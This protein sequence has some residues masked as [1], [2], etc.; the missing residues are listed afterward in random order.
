MRVVGT[1]SQATPSPRLPTPLA[2]TT[3][4]GHPV[5]DAPNPPHQN[6]VGARWRST[7]TKAGLEGQ[8]LHDVRHF[9]ASGLVSRG[10]D[11]VTVQP[12]LGHAR[13]TTT[14]DT[15]S[16]LWPTAE[17]RTRKAAESMMIEAL[18]S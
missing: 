11:V 3:Q 13:A 15:W 9:F 5:L 7:L 14:L 12:A 10:C 8:K 16:H 1:T 4:V 6:T 2:Q 17:D 18:G